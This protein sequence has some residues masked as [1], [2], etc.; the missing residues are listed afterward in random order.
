MLIILLQFK[1]SGQ[2]TVALRPHFNGHES[3]IERLDSTSSAWAGNPMQY[4]DTRSDSVSPIVDFMAWTTSGCPMTTRF[5]LGF[6]GLSDTSI[7]PATA[8][9]LSAK[10]YL[11]GIPSTPTGDYGNSIYPGSPYSIYGQ[12]QGWLYELGSPFYATTCWNTQPTILHND[13][14]SIPVSNLQWGGNDTIDVTAMVADMMVSGNYGFE[15]RMD[16]E[17]KYRERLF[18]SSRYSDTNLHPM[19]I[20]VY[21]IRDG[22]PASVSQFS[23]NEFTIA[24]NPVSDNIL[25]KYKI[26]IEEEIKVTITDILGHTMSM[27]NF[28]LNNGKNDIILPV[29]ELQKGYYQINIIGKHSAFTDKFV[30]I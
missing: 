14:L 27:H 20:V 1:V 8:S 29:K 5:L 30:K 26:S 25:I 4:S 3:H 11:Y 16:T 13:S 19:L 28:I 17:V 9:I 24:P 21:N 12:N 23:K 18:A 6:Q 22:W 2:T 10:L 15:F 7:I